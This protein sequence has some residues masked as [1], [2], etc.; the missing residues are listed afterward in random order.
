MDFTD[1]INMSSIT[2]QE[3][4]EPA[5]T[6]EFEEIKKYFIFGK[7][8]QIKKKFEVAD[9][10]HSDKQIQQLTEFFNLLIVF[11]NALD[12]TDVV[13]LINRLIQN[14]T[15]LT[16]IR[17]DPIFEPELSTVPEPS[18]EIDQ[19]NLVKGG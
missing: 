9:I 5:P 3:E 14:I 7:L 19:S 10:D 6:V 4:Q 16:D 18:A 1:Y 8:K 17:I 12:Y 11:Y 2:E 13:T 15:E